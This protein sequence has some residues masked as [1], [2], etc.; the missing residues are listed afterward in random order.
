M[1]HSATLAFYRKSN[2]H[3]RNRYEELCYNETK[4]SL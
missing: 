1:C 4:K 3:N 2:D